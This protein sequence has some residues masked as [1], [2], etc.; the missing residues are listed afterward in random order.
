MDPKVGHFQY[1]FLRLLA[2][3]L[4]FWRAAVK[5]PP[6]GRNVNFANGQT[7][8]ILMPYACTIKV[9]DASG[10]PARAMHLILI[11]V[12]PLR[13]G[14]VSELLVVDEPEYPLV[15]RHRV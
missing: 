4:L 13:D 6:S 2:V 10:N 5:R 1:N 7:D 14:V 15:P 12:L 3:A 8:R 11:I 9:V